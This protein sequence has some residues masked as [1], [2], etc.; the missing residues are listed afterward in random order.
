MINIPSNENL[1]CS[2]VIVDITDSKT[3]VCSKTAIKP[4]QL[5]PLCVK[6]RY[7][8]ILVP[9]DKNLRLPIAID[10]AHSKPIVLTKVAIKASYLFSPAYCNPV[11][12]HFRLLRKLTCSQFKHRDDLHVLG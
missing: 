4:P 7:I 3:I 6:D 12:L 9:C 10:I 8:V 11:L 2:V 1:L 5:L